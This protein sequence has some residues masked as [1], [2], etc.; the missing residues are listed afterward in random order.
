MNG[1]DGE[2]PVASSHEPSAATGEREEQ[3]LESQ[4][5]HLRDELGE[6]VGEIDRRR[7]EAF[8]L[9]LQMR[10]HA[11]VVAA[12]GGVALVL[13][14]G[15]FAVWRA[16]RR[17]QQNVLERVQNLG[18]AIAIM[19]RNP[20]RLE[21]ALEGRPQP[22]TAAVTALAKLAGAAGQRAILG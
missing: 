8:D 15:G 13:A 9:R 14:I 1:G 17:R 22:G 19:A 21:R 18:R 12:I 7:H 20:D 4:I 10:R 6:I 3:A 2:Q 5:V 11:G 16:S